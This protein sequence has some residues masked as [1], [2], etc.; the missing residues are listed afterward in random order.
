MWFFKYYFILFFLNMSVWVWCMKLNWYCWVD[1]IVV[2]IYVI[3]KNIKFFLIIGKEK[4]WKKVLVG[5]G[6]YVY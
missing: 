4:C 1:E 5:K 6:I 2:F 3:L